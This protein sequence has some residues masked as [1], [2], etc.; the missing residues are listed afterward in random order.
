MGAGD[1]RRQGHR[2]CQCWWCEGDQRRSWQGGRAVHGYLALRR[3]RSG[4]ALFHAYSSCPPVC[5]KPQRRLT[6]CI[7]NEG[8]PMPVAPAWR[9]GR[10]GAVAPAPLRGLPRYQLQVLR[11]CAP[12]PCQSLTTPPFASLPCHRHEGFPRS[13]QEPGSRSRHLHAGRRTRSRQ[14]PLRLLPGVLRHPRP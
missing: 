11:P 4:R 10:G 13:T 2:T 3:P 5:R 1:C 14:A 9:T 8:L 6:R 12:D 7:T